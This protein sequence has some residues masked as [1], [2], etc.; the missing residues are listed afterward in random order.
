MAPLSALRPPIPLLQ[1]QIK[2]VW[3]TLRP[4]LAQI[5][6]PREFHRLV[7]ARRLAREPITATPAL[8]CLLLRPAATTLPTGPLTAQW[9]AALPATRLLRR[10]IKLWSPTSPAS[11]PSRLVFHPLAR[12]QLRAAEP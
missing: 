5:R 10:S 3:R 8:Q 9:S 4:S 12:A 1:L 7:Q 2:P 6:S 11:I